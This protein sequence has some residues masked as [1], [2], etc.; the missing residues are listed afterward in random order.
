MTEFDKNIDRDDRYY[1]DGSSTPL[2]HQLLNTPKPMPKPFNP[3]RESMIKIRKGLPNPR[4]IQNEV[5]TNIMGDSDYSEADG[6]F[7]SDNEEVMVAGNS[8]N[9]SS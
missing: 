9:F 3:P 2:K 6:V 5:T 1:G 7:S 8:E 4:N